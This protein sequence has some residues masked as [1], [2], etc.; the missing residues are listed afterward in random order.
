M[1]VH[2]LKTGFALAL[3]NQQVIGGALKRAGVRYYSQNHQDYFQD[4]L[5]TYAIMWEQTEFDD[6]EQFNRYA[7]QKIVWQT[8]DSLRRE[9]FGKELIK[10]DEDILLEMEADGQG[11]NEIVM[12]LHRIWPQL[13]YLESQ[14]L[15]QHLLKQIKLTELAKELEVS[16]RYLRIIRCKLRNKLWKILKE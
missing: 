2:N 7:Y 1:K 14:V 11:Y 3:D 5:L 8:L 10:N 15:G 13:S 12:E 6:I 4:G 9:Q 16:D